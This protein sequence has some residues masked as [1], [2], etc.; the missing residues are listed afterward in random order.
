LDNPHFPTVAQEASL[1]GLPSNTGEDRGRMSQPI[2]AA[3]LMLILFVAAGSLVLA[4]SADALDR[5]GRKMRAR[6]AALKAG[7]EA[8]HD[9]YHEAMFDQSFYANRDNVRSLTRRDER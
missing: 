9:A 1:R 5:I 7:R 8:Y 6:G 2:N 4:W 3:M